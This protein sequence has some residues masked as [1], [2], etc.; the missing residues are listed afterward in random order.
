M[1]TDL[2][3]WQA[4]IERFPDQAQV[5]AEGAMGA[6]V[7]FLHGQLPPYPGPAP[8]GEAAKHW[9]D[10]QRRFFF[11]ALRR[12][13]IKV[14]YVRTGTLGRSFTERVTVEPGAVVGE[15]GT[16]LS[17]APWVVGPRY[18]GEQIGGRQRWQARIHAGRWWRLDN[19]FAQNYDAAWGVFADEFFS[20]FSAAVADEV[21]AN[22]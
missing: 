9:T 6:A 13:Q 7:R 3:L 20:R 5:A 19:E 11:A 21:I 22:G 2:E 10:K 4:A 17:Y 1:S 8:K 16:N 14:P 18:P 12:G 15:L